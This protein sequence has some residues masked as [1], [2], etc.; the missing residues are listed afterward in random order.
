MTRQ[1]CKDKIMNF[2]DRVFNNKKDTLPTIAEWS[3]EVT[4]D[5]CDML[6]VVY[7]STIRTWELREKYTKHCFPI[8]T[9]EFLSSMQ[10]FCNQFDKISEFACG[11]GWLSYWMKKYGIKI[12]SSVDDKSW[13]FKNYLD[14]VTKCDAEMYLRRNLEIDLIIMSWPNYNDNFAY[15]IW[16]RMR[17]GQY[18]LYI[19]EGHGGCTADADFHKAIG[20]HEVD[21]KWSLSENFVSFWGIHDRPMVYKK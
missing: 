20:G 8:L 17:K 5:D 10:K 6:D 3:S 19:G 21:D 15:K 7:K 2:L 16:Q 9:H 13:K 14:F 4:F 1:N 11:E 12:H 18:L